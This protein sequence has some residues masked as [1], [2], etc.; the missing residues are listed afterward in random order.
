MNLCLSADNRVKLSIFCFKSQ[1]RSILP[2]DAFLSFIALLHRISLV[3]LYIHPGNIQNLLENLLNI[4]I[5]CNEDPGSHTIHLFQ[6]G[7]KHMLGS[8][9]I[10]TEPQRLIH[11]LVQYIAQTGAELRTFLKGHISYRR[12][13]LIHDLID[14]FLFQSICSENLSRNACINLSEPQKQMLCPHIRV[15]KLLCGC[16]CNP[17]NLICLFRIIHVVSSF[18]FYNHVNSY[19]VYSS[20]I[21]STSSCTSSRLIFLQHPFASTMRSS[22]LISS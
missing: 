7:K 22:C 12:D 2:E 17:Q 13:Q 5:Q 19:N 3:F 6:H 8:N 4:N 15:V 21:L 16:L 20:Y 9:L 11:T 14:I 18:L 1:I 10:R